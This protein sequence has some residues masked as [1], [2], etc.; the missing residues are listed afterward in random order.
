MRRTIHCAIRSL[1]FS[2][3]WYFCLLNHVSLV[4]CAVY[5]VINGYDNDRFLRVA[6]NFIMFLYLIS[7]AFY[8]SLATTICLYVCS[9][10]F[11]FYYFS[12]VLYSYA[13][14]IVFYFRIL[15]CFCCIHASLYFRVDKSV[16]VKAMFY[17][18]YFNDNH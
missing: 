4:V 9:F 10:F 11:S 13:L 3:S 18:N 17:S 6:N 16:N 1:S 5:D 12:F 2:R 8:N 14:C 7:L 15:F